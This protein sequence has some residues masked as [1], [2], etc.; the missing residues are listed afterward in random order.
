M[1]QVL[2]PASLFFTVFSGG[3]WQKHLTIQGVGLNVCLVDC[4]YSYLFPI[5]IILGNA[6]K[7]FWF[8]VFSDVVLLIFLVYRLLGRWVCY[9]QIMINT[10]TKCFKHRI[11]NILGHQDRNEVNNNYAIEW[12]TVWDICRTSQKG[13]LI[14]QYIKSFHASDIA[15]Y[16]FE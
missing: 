9:Q 8:T 5:I 1:L 15:V 13:Y 12:L 14:V 4:N 2:K 16:G 11:F 6:S 7:F 10:D 3:R